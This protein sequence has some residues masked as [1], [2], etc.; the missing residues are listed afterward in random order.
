MITRDLARAALARQRRKRSFALCY[1]GVGET[2]IRLDPR[3]L[4]V[5]PRCLVSQIELLLDAGYEFVTLSELVASAPQSGW[6]PK[7]GLVAL[8]FD[9]GWGD[10]HGTLLPILAEYRVPATIYVTTGLMGGPNPWLALGSGGRMMTEEEV[11]ACARAGVEIGAH[12]LTHPDLSLVGA[13]GCRREVGGSRDVLREL[14]GAPIGSFAYP[15]FH[16]GPEA[17]DAVREAGF[18]SAVA[19]S[20]DTWSPLTFERTPI[21]GK[22]GLASFVLKLLGRYDPLLD[23]PPVRVARG[24]TRS[25]R[26]RGRE[27]LDRGA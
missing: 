1:H 12:T 15:Y 22:D 21:S 26:R 3:F 17:V 14:T 9:D 24:A 6:P 25:V 27:L 16:T 23:L 19:G 11:V 13:D 18:D 10:N 7:P 20:G 2:S 8:T 4:R 5:T